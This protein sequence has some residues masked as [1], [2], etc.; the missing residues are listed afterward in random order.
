MIV[1]AHHHFWNPARISQGWMTAE[2]A[3]INRAFE[4]H[5]L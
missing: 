4:V 2:H 5:D 1:D 3:A